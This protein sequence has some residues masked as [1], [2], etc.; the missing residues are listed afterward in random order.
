MDDTKEVEILDA[1]F[2][3]QIFD[4]SKEE[5]EKF[6]KEEEKSIVLDYE[7][8]K[9]FLNNK[10]LD[11]L[12]NKT[13]SF[14]EQLSIYF[15]ERLER[16]VKIRIKNLPESLR[17]LRIRDI[18]SEHKDKLIQ[19]EGIIKISSEVRPFIIKTKYLH[20]DC[21]GEF[22]VENKNFVIEKPKK[23]PVCGGTKGKFIET[24]HEQ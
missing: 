10:Q 5:I 13:E 11:L 8:I 18:R 14:L 24:D 1:G 9:S 6:I 4:A 17:Y 21:G 15:S 7:K 2:L 3:G 23:C 16:K 20:E 22:W 19:V 12:L